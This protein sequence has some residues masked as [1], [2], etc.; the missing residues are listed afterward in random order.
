MIV[1]VCWADYFNFFFSGSFFFPDDWT[2]L[3]GNYS[4]FG[5]GLATIMFDVLFLIQHYLLY[6]ESKKKPTLSPITRADLGTININFVPDSVSFR[7]THDKNKLCPNGVS[8][9]K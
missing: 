8:V 2:F 3:V 9:R 7:T 1:D 4:K 6:P 5:I